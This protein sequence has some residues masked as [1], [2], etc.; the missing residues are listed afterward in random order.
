[1]RDEQPERRHEREQRGGDAAAAARADGDAER[2]ERAEGRRAAEHE[3][4]PVAARGG[5]EPAGR[6]E[7]D[8]RGDR[9]DG[10]VE[11]AV[12]ALLAVRDQRREEREAE[13]RDE[14]EPGRSCEQRR[15]DGQQVGRGRDAEEADAHE[16][17]PAEQQR[18]LQRGA[19][20][21][22]AGDDRRRG[23]DPE[24][25]QPERGLGR[26]QPELLLG[27]EEEERRERRVAEHPQHLRRE[28]GGHAGPPGR[29]EVVPARARRPALALDPAAA[30]ARARQGRQR[31]EREEDGGHEER[32]PERDLGQGA[33]DGDPCEPAAE[34]RKLLRTRGPRSLGCSEPLG[35]ECAMDGGDGVEA[36]VD[37][38]TG[39][40]QHQVCARRARGR[41][42]EAT[43]AEEAPADDEGAPPARALDAVAPDADDERH[44]EAGDR[45]DEHDGADEPRRIV[46]LVEE[47]RQVRGRDGARETGAGRRRRERDEWEKREPARRGARGEVDGGGDG[48][49]R[50]GLAIEKAAG[51][52]RISTGPVPMVVVSATTGQRPPVETRT[53]ARPPRPDP[54]APDVGAAA[55]ANEVRDECGAARRLDGDEV[56]E[57]VARVGVGSDAKPER[58]EREVDDEELVQARELGRVVA[59]DE[60]GTGLEPREGRRGGLDTRAEV[61][62]VD[63]VV[64]R[65]RDRVEADADALERVNG[66]PVRGRGDEVERADAALDG[67]ARRGGEVDRDRQAV[68]NVVGPAGGEKRD[69]GLRPVDVRERVHRAVAAQ[70]HDAPVGLVHEVRELV[71]RRRHVRLDAGAPVAELPD[72][73]V[74][75]LAVAAD[76]ARVAV[77]DQHQMARGA[78]AG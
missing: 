31:E 13:C 47:Q 44:D 34:E 70:Q 41:R 73:A 43:G 19:P 9:A 39:P 27:V 72:G 55:H 77:R 58:E 15:G 8:G 23:R 52:R 24:G 7:G 59:L 76:A 78:C 28:E 26:A 69:L 38:G 66:L 2:H 36:D 18:P 49:H 22:A 20:H 45:V 64:A 46:D 4:R 25:R 21:A 74:E 14:T 71:Q 48:G 16:H 62:R 61:G 11:R 30:A 10:E 6:G 17:D 32:R 51:S 67:D 68:R 54:A 12:A 3:Q 40:G 53:L 1:M 37:D 50:P 33:A 29:G 60:H 35:D 63:A 42:D 57:P 65:A 56:E 5:D 75:D